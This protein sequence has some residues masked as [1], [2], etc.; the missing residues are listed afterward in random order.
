MKSYCTIFL[1]L[2]V[3]CG[4]NHRKEIRA[5]DG[6]LRVELRD[7]NER[8]DTVRM[9]RARD[10]E[11]LV[12]KFYVVNNSGEPMVITD[13]VTGCGC[14]VV[15]YDKKAIG[16]GE[17]RLFNFSFDTR[18]RAGYQLKGIDIIDSRQRVARILIEAE[19]LIK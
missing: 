11:M 18:G 15:D 7:D 1:L 3:A 8:F 2:M 5:R 16:A 4:G 6:A 14:T 19:V 9:G 17:E 13:V 12:G 10:G